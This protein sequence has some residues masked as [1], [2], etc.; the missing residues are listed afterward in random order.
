MSLVP[1]THSNLVSSRTMR[2]NPTEENF[3]FFFK[4]RKLSLD[5]YCGCSLR[6]GVQISSI[7]LFFIALAHFYSLFKETNYYS[8]ISTVI[9]VILYLAASYYLFIAA[10]NVN[11]DFS[12]VGYNILCFIFL[13]DLSDYIIVIVL[14]FVGYFDIYL[15]TRINFF[16]FG[17]ICFGM[18]VMLAELYFM[19]LAFCFTIH[20]KLK[21]MHIVYGDSIN[22]YLDEQPLL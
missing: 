19:W 2:I 14:T 16:I 15:T 7:I 6:S 3:L 17:F 22:E 21:R 8:I 11:E 10:Y 20:V 9:L 13:V 5:S 1:P 4:A 18:G 12:K